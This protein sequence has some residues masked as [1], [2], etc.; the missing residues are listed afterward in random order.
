MPFLVMLI[1]GKEG[2]VDIGN[3]GSE[4]RSSV[5]NNDWNALFETL[6]FCRGGFYSVNSL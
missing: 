5:V 2:C 3:V 1:S 4:L 6:A